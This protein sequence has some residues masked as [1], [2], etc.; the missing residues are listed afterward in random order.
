[1]IMNH[2]VDDHTVHS[3]KDDDLVNMPIEKSVVGE[4]V[5]PVEENLDGKIGLGQKESQ[6]VNLA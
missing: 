5:H 1:M 6:E 4:S 3:G 2:E